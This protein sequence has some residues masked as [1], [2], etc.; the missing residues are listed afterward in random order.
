MHVPVTII[1]DGELLVD[2]LRD[3]GKNEDWLM[4]QLKTHNVMDVRN[5]LIAESLKND[6]LFVQTFD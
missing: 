1:R 5:V 3:I 2:G 6:G 4:V